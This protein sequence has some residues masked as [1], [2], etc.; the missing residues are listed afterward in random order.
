MK[1]SLLKLKLTRPLDKLVNKRF[2]LADIVFK[3]LDFSCP[4]VTIPVVFFQTFATVPI[5]KYT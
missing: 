1:E 3:M 4:D 2:T 5:L